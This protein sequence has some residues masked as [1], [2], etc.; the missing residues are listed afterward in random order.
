M[1]KTEHS[2][3]YQRTNAPDMTS[4]RYEPCL[5]TGRSAAGEAIL[6]AILERWTPLPD[7]RNRYRYF[8]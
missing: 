5:A 6:Q 3:R 1:A 2:Q 8:R 7:F 4:S